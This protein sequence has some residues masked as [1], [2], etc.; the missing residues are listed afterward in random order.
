MD[1]GANAETDIHVILGTSS[2]HEG[3]ENQAELVVSFLVM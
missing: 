1:F 2:S 3:S